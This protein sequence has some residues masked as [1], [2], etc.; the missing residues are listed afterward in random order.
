MSKSPV[1]W[2]EGR[3]W[4]TVSRKIAFDRVFL[5]TDA[6]GVGLNLQSGSLL[7]NLDIPWNPAVLEQRIAR[8]HRMGQKKPVRIINFISRGSI[9]ERILALLGFKKSLSAGALDEDG[10]D[11]V[12]LGES[13]MEQFMS[14]VEEATDGLEREDREAGSAQLQEEELAAAEA[15]VEPEPQEEEAAPVTAGAAAAGSDNAALQTLL[16]SG[17]K[18][19]QSL[20]EALSA[21]PPQSGTAGQP[22]EQLV[23][24][25]VARDETTGKPYLKIPMPEPETVNAI[26]SGLQAL[27]RKVG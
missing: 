26:V 7:I 18:L 20:S 9:E 12:M 5:S 24:R 2:R 13:Q 6:G 4:N 15:A 1:R 3:F 10:Q 19:L 8:I 21:P 17:A 16:A 14:S 23:Q 27:F 11:V 22:G 25:L